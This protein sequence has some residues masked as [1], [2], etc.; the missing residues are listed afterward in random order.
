M[1]PTVLSL[2]GLPIDKNFQGRD[3]QSEIQLRKNNSQNIKINKTSHSVFS[4]T[5][6]WMPQP[7]FAVRTLDWKYI[8]Q[9]NRTLVYQLSSDPDEEN[10]KSSASDDFLQDAQKRYQES[11]EAKSFLLQQTSSKNG[12]NRHI[13]DEE[14]KRLEALGYTTCDKK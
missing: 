11:I 8:Q 13:S 3:L 6:P 7:Q 5:D 10:L 4:I 9:E 2:A 14:C 1:T 12:L